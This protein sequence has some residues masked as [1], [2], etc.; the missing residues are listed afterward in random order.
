MN[1]A[2]YGV[3]MAALLVCSGAQARCFAYAAEKFGVDETLLR[4]IARVES[5]F[6]EQALNINTNHS[7]DIGMMQINSI[8]RATLEKAGL[9]MTDLLDPCTNVIVGAWLLESAIRR[10]DGDVWKGV[11]R[12]HSA[13]PSR[14]L[15]YIRRVRKAHAALYPGADSDHPAARQAAHPAQPLDRP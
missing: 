6:N 9:A 4:A 11:G 2:L 13:T 7:Y 8:H 15:T 1:R 3:V 12:Y 14:A 5:G 10:S